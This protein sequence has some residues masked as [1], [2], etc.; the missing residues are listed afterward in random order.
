V[1]RHDLG[2]PLATTGEEP[3]TMQ[4]VLRQITCLFA[5]I[6]AGCASGAGPGTGPA[7][8]TTTDPG[9]NG[10]ATATAPVG[11]AASSAPA[12]GTEPTSSTPPAP[13]TNAALPA[14][15]P[16]ATPPPA[17][18]PPVTSVPAPASLPVWPPPVDALVLPAPDGP[19]AVG[20][21]AADSPGTVVFYPAL[22]GTGRGRHRYV[23]PAL[24]LAAGLDPAQMDRV[25]ST[26]QIDATPAPSDAPRPVV[27]LMPGW[28]SIVALSTALAEDLAS[29]G[30][31]VLA[32][33]TDVVAEWS[34]PRSTQ[35]D[36]DKRFA[37]LDR[38]LD[39]LQDPSLPA[40][41]GPIDLGRIAVGGHSYA[42][43]IAFDASLTDQRIAVMFD[44]DGSARGAA[45]RS[46]PTRPSLVVVTVNDG[47]VSDPQLGD[48]ASRSQHIV[49]V[50][51]LNA[52]HLD[53][54]DA[55][56]I[57]SLLGTSVFSTLLGA[58]G[59]TG[60]TDASTIV[61]RFL[62][63][64]LGVTPRQPSSGELV[65]GLPSATADPFGSAAPGSG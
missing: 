45:D 49:A 5:L 40:L 12:V 56:S 24:A 2:G 48:L 54:T 3:T 26:A 50:G 37:L 21:A 7:S 64:T 39:F 1:V 14:T 60:T 30:Y 58:V 35:E 63:A 41:V 16:P 36:R 33:Q 11:S 47:A 52:L 13:T 8:T 19:A 28:R 62:D 23:D 46:P 4:R 42:G 38:V 20:I 32:T 34:H 22:P 44:L 15:P 17:T 43:S 25:V 18:P 9:A 51:V 55:A 6:T 29:H 53:V 61:W 65:Q 31:V 57:P 59:S 27:L 10:A